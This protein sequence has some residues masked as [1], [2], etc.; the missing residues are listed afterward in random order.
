MRC[1]AGDGPR[2]VV[3]A[4]LLQYVITGDE[5]SLRKQDSVSMTQI[6]KLGEVAIVIC[7]Q[8]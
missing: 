7:P 4:A 3:W 1:V 6:R 2:D 5:Q 8:Q